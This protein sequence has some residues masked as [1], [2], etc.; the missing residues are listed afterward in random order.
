M[1]GS[2]GKKFSKKSS[3]KWQESQNLQKV[4]LK[5]INKHIDQ[6]PSVNYT[7]ERNDLKAKDLRKNINLV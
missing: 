4:K 7:N 2:N 5:L 3:H 6:L 1:I